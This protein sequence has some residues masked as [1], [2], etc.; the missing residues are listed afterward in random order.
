M[1]SNQGASIDLM[2]RNANKRRS[3][4][5]TLYEHKHNADAIHIGGYAM[6]LG[7]KYY[8]GKKNRMNI[9]PN[10]KKYKT[11]DLSGL[12][13]EADLQ[14]DLTPVLQRHFDLIISYWRGGRMRYDDPRLHYRRNARRFKR[15]LIGKNDDGLFYWL[16]AKWTS[17]P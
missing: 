5:L 7:L 6:E 11:H 3:S 12:L 10:G 1:I 4:F 8:I 13:K 14:R 17:L 2:R 15:A 9:W 16:K